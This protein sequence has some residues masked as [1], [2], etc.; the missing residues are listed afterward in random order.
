MRSTFNAIKNR[1]KLAYY[2]RQCYMIK[3]AENLDL[4]K[5]NLG[6][7]DSLMNFWVNFSLQ[8]NRL[9][10]LH[11]TR[12]F[13]NTRQTCLLASN[14]HI[15]TTSI[16]PHSELKQQLILL[17]KSLNFTIMSLLK[18]RGVVRNSICRSHAA[19]A[20]RDVCL[21]INGNLVKFEDSL[22]PFR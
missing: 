20:K 14:I 21:I 5:G 19:T 11:K 12:R 3:S 17:L 10:N 4:R 15:R 6:L 2:L 9:L 7:F 18:R 13:D 16:T 8:S 22:L 1:P